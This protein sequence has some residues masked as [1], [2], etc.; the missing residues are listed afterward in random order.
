M[1]H[2]VL[3]IL[4][5]DLGMYFLLKLKRAIFIQISCARILRRCLITLL[6]QF[7]SVIINKGP[8]PGPQIFST[9]LIGPFLQWSLGQRSKYQA[10]IKTPKEPHDNSLFKKKGIAGLTVKTQT[11]LNARVTRKRKNPG[12]VNRQKSISEINRYTRYQ[13]ISIADCYRLISVID[14]NLTYRKNYRFLSIGK[15]DN[16]R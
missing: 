2:R 6:S 3:L 5:L 16:N 8:L 14:N 13:S 9:R 7:N 11:I 12:V 4:Y 10:R 1:V 15:I